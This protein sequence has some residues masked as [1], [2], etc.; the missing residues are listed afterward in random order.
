ME[1]QLGDALL[2]RVVVLQ[3]VLG[4]QVPELDRAIR[5]PRRH[6]R[7][8][9]VELAGGDEGRVVVE[10]VDAVVGPGVPELDSLVIAT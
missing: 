10:G 7:A 5:R 4:T 2:M 3:K 9:G 8:V 1:G 6:A